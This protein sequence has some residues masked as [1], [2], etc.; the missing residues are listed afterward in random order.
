MIRLMYLIHLKPSQIRLLLSIELKF[1]EANVIYHS[2]VDSLDEKQ[3]HDL[4]SIL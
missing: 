1:N 4:K 3:E 2:F